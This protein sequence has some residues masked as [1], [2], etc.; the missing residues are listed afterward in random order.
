MKRSLL[1]DSIDKLRLCYC[2]KDDVAYVDDF[3]NN[4]TQ[5]TWDEF[6]KQADKVPYDDDKICDFTIKLKNKTWLY[7]YKI[8]DE[9]KWL[10][11]QS[12]SK[13]TLK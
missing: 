11:L 3:Y 6:T 13:F 9:I 4:N 5:L 7:R 10:H 1:Q 2:T 8:D 12:H